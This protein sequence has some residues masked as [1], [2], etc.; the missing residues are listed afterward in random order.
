MKILVVEDDFT[1]AQTLQHLLSS[2]H[3]AVDTA[4]DGEAGLQL[5]EVYEYDL[6][7]LDVVL[8]RLDGIGLCQQLRTKGFQFPILLLTGQGGSRQKAIALNA[9]ADDYVV[10]PFDPEELMARVQALLRRGG[11]Q[12]KPLLQWGK[13]AIDPSSR[14]VTYGD[15]LLAILSTQRSILLRSGRHF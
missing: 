10:K 1:V 5:A 4:A 3:Y 6:A 14:R 8:P 9:G 15:Q 13:L 11:P 7:L 12:T 2:Y